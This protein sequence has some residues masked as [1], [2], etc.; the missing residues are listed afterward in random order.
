MSCPVWLLGT[1]SRSFARAVSA[2]DLWAISPA[3]NLFLRPSYWLMNIWVVSVCINRIL[4]EHSR[5]V[6]MWTGHIYGFYPLGISLREMTE[7]HGSSV[8]NIYV[9]T[10]WEIFKLFFEVAMPL[11]N[12]DSNILG[13]QILYNFANTCYCLFFY[14]CSMDMK[15]YLL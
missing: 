1:Q 6:L 14:N 15:Q 4:Y 9:L 7:P 13:L 8:F 12:P 5:T 11:Y 10:F 2:Y 3:L